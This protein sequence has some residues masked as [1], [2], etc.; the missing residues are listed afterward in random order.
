[1]VA[2]LIDQG[3]QF[4]SARVEQQRASIGEQRKPVR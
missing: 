4:L 1:L 3:Q 2:E